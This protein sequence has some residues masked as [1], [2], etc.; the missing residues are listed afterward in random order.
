[1]EIVSSSF[2]R[3]GAIYLNYGEYEI[4][5]GY[6]DSALNTADLIPIYRLKLPRLLISE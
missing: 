2:R 3:I 4:A 5:A 6:F 1:M